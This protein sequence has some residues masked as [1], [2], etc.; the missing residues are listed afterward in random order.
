MAKWAGLEL[1]SGA[2]SASAITLAV[3]REM[4]TLAPKKPSVVLSDA[5]SLASADAHE[6]K[7]RA[8]LPGGMGVRAAHW[9]PLP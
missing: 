4:A 9:L 3:S 8:G 7:G 6:D 1:L 2:W 5:V